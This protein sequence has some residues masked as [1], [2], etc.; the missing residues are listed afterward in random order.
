MQRT[1]NRTM[2]GQTGCGKEV[3]GSED[4]LGQI[5][6]T[7]ASMSG[8]QRVLVLACHWRFF[9]GQ[10]L[11]ALKRMASQVEYRVV[12][13]P[14]AGLV[15]ADWVVTALETGADAVVVLGGH[16]HNCPFAREDMQE[17]DRLR[18]LIGRMGFDPDRFVIDWTEEDESAPFLKAVD[19]LVASID[20][21]GPP[22]R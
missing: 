6:E 2:G 8:D 14:C 16:P 5:K 20:E 10:D 1:M 21:L 15:S 22:F 19:E 11:D 13:T 18:S 3:E 17:E 4:V 9:A 12:R 7:A